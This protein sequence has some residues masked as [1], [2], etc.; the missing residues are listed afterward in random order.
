MSRRTKIFGFLCGL[1][2]V[3]MLPVCVAMENLPNIDHKAVIMSVF[4]A[5]FGLCFVLAMTGE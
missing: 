4:I 3:A 1:H 2:I 5:T